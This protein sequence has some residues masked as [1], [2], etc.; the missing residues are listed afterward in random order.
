MTQT[1]KDK[2]QTGKFL[3]RGA[4]LLSTHR[5]NS[6][7]QIGKYMIFQHPLCI[8]MYLCMRETCLSQSV[9]KKRQLSFSLN[10]GVSGYVQ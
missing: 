7:E 5:N 4:K 8:Q 2:K 10:A 9:R 1:C 3:K 6:I